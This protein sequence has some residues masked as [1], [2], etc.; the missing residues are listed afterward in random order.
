MGEKS[1]YIIISII[2]IFFYFIQ[3]IAI[4]GCYREYLRYR[5]IRQT[6]ISTNKF[7]KLTGL[8]LL[9]IK[10]G[11][12]I[13]LKIALILTNIQ[14]LFIPLLLILLASEIVGVNFFIEKKVIS[15]II[16]IIF[17]EIVSIFIGIHYI[18][19]IRFRKK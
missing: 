18:L 2:I 8:Y 1:Y 13:F 9:F 3:R 16:Y 14:L 7:Y 11:Q 15:K 4:Y 10:Q 6:K 5:N 17:W 12:S 19:K